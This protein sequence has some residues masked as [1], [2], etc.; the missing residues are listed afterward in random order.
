MNENRE[1][2]TGSLGGGDRRRLSHPRRVAR[3]VEPFAT[4]VRLDFKLT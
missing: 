1:R 3:R 4:T 2:Q